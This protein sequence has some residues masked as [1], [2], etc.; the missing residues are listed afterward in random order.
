MGIEGVDFAFDAYW[1]DLF[2]PEKDEPAVLVCDERI[3]NNDAF[4]GWIVLTSAVGRSHY[5]RF[6]IPGAIKFKD[7]L[8]ATNGAV[9]K[10]C[11]VDVMTSSI[12]ALNNFRDRAIPDLSTRFMEERAYY[13]NDIPCA[14][15]AVIVP[16][17]REEY[18]FDDSAR[19]LDANFRCSE[20]CLEANGK[21]HC[22]KVK[23]GFG[24]ALHYDSTINACE[25]TISGD[26][27]QASPSSFLEMSESESESES[28]ET[29]FTE[30]L[31]LEDIQNT[32]T[33]RCF[34]CVCDGDGFVDCALSDEADI[35]RSSAM[36]S[37]PEK[38][39]VNGKIE[40]THGKNRYDMLD[41]AIDQAIS[42]QFKTP[43]CGA[44][45]KDMKMRN[46][47][48]CDENIFGENGPEFYGGTICWYHLFS[49]S[50]F[51]FTVPLSSLRGT[52]K[53]LPARQK[54]E[55]WAKNSR[56]VVGD[57]LG[58]KKSADINVLYLFDRFKASFEYSEE[59]TEKLKLGKHMGLDRQCKALSDPTFD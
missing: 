7:T 13:N 50:C 53:G 51:P 39:G 19:L 1:S 49:R 31:H 18:D 57:F 10:A 33:G 17:D 14:A 24:E 9:E 25:L 34:A 22:P 58:H 6:N 45:D 44:D 23:D 52:K 56:M 43:M 55:Q 40:R 11:L 4:S 46:F 27:A 12:S 28:K 35:Y 38:D 47:A 8:G 36:H 48:V 59:A 41:V 21:D 26:A 5:I 32:A 15:D 16:E 2:N 54:M 37:P 3:Y 42:M 29:R 30:K 20:K